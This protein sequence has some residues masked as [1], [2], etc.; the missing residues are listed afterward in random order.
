MRELSK[1]KKGI[2]QALANK[3]KQLPQSQIGSK[4]TSDTLLAQK[5]MNDQE[6]SEKQCNMSTN[7]AL[8]PSLQEPFVTKLRSF[9][10]NSQLQPLAYTM[11]SFLSAEAQPFVKAL[12]ASSEA[13]V[14]KTGQVSVGPTPTRQHVSKQHKHPESSASKPRQED[15]IHVV[16]DSNSLHRRKE[17]RSSGKMKDKKGKILFP[18]KS[19]PG[20]SATATNPQVNLPQYHELRNPPPYQAPPGLQVKAPKPEIPAKPNFHPA[21]TSSRSLD[22]KMNL[23]DTGN[24]AISARRIVSPIRCSSPEAKTTTLLMPVYRAKSYEDLLETSEHGDARYK[25][26]GPVETRSSSQ[27]RMSPPSESDRDIPVVPREFLHRSRYSPS[28][29][30]QQAAVHDQSPRHTP[31]LPSSHHLLARHT[32]PERPRS[33]ELLSEYCSGLPRSDQHT[34]VK[35]GRRKAKVPHT[36]ATLV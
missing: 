29:G 36:H 8:H 13:R 35:N 1:S 28:P 5:S 6:S 27:L 20:Q 30:A 10:H 19:K 17:R 3:E 25:S 4:H 15:L 34:A 33:A 7:P 32:Q 21:H 26:Y 23:Q 2:K 16:F 18:F 11:Q 9:Q 22:Q 24:V 14:V 31:S 12:Q